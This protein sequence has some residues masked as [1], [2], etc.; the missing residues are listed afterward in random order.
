MLFN[1]ITNN[2]TTKKTINITVTYSLQLI[3][4]GT[5]YFELIPVP[6]LGQVQPGYFASNIH[7]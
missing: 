1:M 2:N 4:V 3:F 6:D 5:F 7:K